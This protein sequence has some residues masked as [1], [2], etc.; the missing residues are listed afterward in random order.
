MLIFLLE[1][2]DG[3]EEKEELHEGIQERS[4]ESCN[5]TGI[6]IVRGGEES[7]GPHEP[8]EAVEKPDRERRERRISRQGTHE[9]RTGRDPPVAEGGQAALDGKGNIKKSD[10][11][12]CQ[13]VEVRCGFIRQQK[14]AFPISLLCRV[15]GVSRSGYYKY[16]GRDPKE[17]MMRE[18]PLFSKVRAIQK[19]A[20]GSYGSRRMSRQLCKDGHQI[21][22][23]RAGSLMKKAGAEF[24]PRKKFR[25]TTDS[26]HKHP[27]AANLLSRQ[28]EVDR[29]DRVWCADITYLWTLQ[30]WLY[31]A[32]ILDLFSRKV[33]G[34]A[35]SKRINGQLVVDALRMAYWRRKP[36]AGLLHHSDRGSQYAA[37]AYQDELKKDNMVCSMSRKGNCWDNAVAE[38]FFRSLKTERTDDTLYITRHEAKAD[39]VDYIEMFY[40]SY[41]LHSSLEYN[42]PNQYEARRGI[43][44]KVA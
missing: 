13:R 3:K 5:G 4:G 40:N 33:V 14:K 17:K 41:R 15:L 12:L 22:R 31:L 6:Q 21:G 42:S 23:H 7:G 8:F 11:L 20:K 25:R 10:G 43:L 36:S 38:S 24:R 2:R 37:K 44:A 26:G 28:F 16:L 19:R 27:V 39:V 29:P 34:W 32:V 18:F 9:S 30:G 35:M 1:V